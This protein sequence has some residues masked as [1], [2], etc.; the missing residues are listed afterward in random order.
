MSFGWRGRRCII[1]QI[2]SCSCCRR[3]SRTSAEHQNNVQLLSSRDPPHRS[4]A[5]CGVCEDHRKSL[6]ADSQSAFLRALTT[7]ISSVVV[8]RRRNWQ[9]HLPLHL[10]TPPSMHAI[11]AVVSARPKGK[12]IRVSNSGQVRARTGGRAGRRM[13]TASETRQTICQTPAQTDH[14]PNREVKTLCRSSKQTV[15]SQ[16]RYD[17]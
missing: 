2:A 5:R 17:C 16:C 4:L 6:P 13:G 3:C 7:A 11:G 12:M 10:P 15:S 14:N 9:V 1:C 8:A